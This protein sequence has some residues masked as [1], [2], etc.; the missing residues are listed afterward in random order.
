MRR[1]R[2]SSR[3]AGRQFYERTR[4]ASFLGESAAWHIDYCAL[5]CDTSAE[6]RKGKPVARRGRKAYEPLEE[7]VGLP[8]KRAAWYVTFM[9]VWCT[10]LFLSNAGEAP[11]EE[12]RFRRDFPGPH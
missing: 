7:V 3:G 2:P 12:L 5:L 4:M 11:A 10:C 1:R 9:A 6:T 8:K